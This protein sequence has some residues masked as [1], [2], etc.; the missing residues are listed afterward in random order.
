MTFSR[1][2]FNMQSKRVTEKPGFSYTG[3]FEIERFDGVKMD[4]CRCGMTK[5]AFKL[6]G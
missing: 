1:F 5:E 2:P 4:D 3:Y 6:K